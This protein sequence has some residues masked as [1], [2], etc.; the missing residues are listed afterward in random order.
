MGIL[1]AFAGKIF[2][3][4]RP[5]LI[6]HVPRHARL[7]ARPPCQLLRGR[8]GIGDRRTSLLAEV[9]HGGSGLFDD[10]AGEFR[11]T[12]P[13]STLNASSA[14]GK[15]DRRG[16]VVMSIRWGDSDPPGDRIR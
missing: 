15:C 5:L 11:H 9:A 1:V 8:A 7:L 16:R 12:S 14:A 6:E 3:G 4:A 13:C 10:I 2:A